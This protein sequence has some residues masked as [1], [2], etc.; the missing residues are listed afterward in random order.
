MEYDLYIHYDYRPMSQAD[1]NEQKTAPMVES[2]IE[3]II[4]QILSD[5]ST[6]SE[7]IQINPFGN[8]YQKL[9]QI[10]RVSVCDVPNE[11]LLYVSLHYGT[12]RNLC[13]S[14]IQIKDLDSK[15]VMIYNQVDL[16]FDYMLEYDIESSLKQGRMVADPLGS[17]QDTQL[18][19]GSN[20]IKKSWS[21]NICI[22]F[23]CL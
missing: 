13:E 9:Y 14:F 1:E 17:S 22:G 8:D 4:A 12:I 20:D 7:E 3:D 15:K 2:S 18:V 6:D 23:L 21:A 5:N 19:Y 16:D 10:L 11:V